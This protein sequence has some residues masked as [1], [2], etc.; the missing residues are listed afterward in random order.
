M[1]KLL[2]VFWRD[3]ESAENLRRR[4]LRD[5]TPQIYALGA[6]RL[7]FNVADFADLSGALVNFTLHNTK[8]VPDG[9]V[10]FW[11]T[12]AYRRAPLEALLAATF[13][14][15][16]GYEV[17]E[18]T[19]LPNLRHPPHADERTYGFSQVTFLQVP[20]AAG[21][22]RVAPDLVRGAHA[23]RDRDAGELPLH[24]QCG[25]DA[26]HPGS[27][28]VSRHRRGVLSASGA[29]GLAGV[30]RRRRRRGR[31]ISATSSS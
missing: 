5:V 20:A 18:S 27:A 7:Q 19:I 25:R 16:A 22:R 12:S 28:A 11:L 15:I 24:A 21:L 9:I 30:L 8:P 13:P 4:F 31:V 23:G 1:E 14:R 10:S 2:Y 29:A 17:T 6:E 3:Q 26:P